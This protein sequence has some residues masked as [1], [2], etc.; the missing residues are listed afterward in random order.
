[1]IRRPP[2]ATRTDPLFPYTTLFRSTSEIPSDTR[3]S[4]CHDPISAPRYWTEPEQFPVAGSDPM[5]ELSSVDL[6]APLPPITVTMLPRVTA[7]LA[8]TTALTLPYRAERSVTCRMECLGL[9]VLMPHLR[10]RWML[11][12]GH[13]WHQAD[14]RSRNRRLCRPDRLPAR[15]DCVEC[16]PAGLRP[17]WCR[18]P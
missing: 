10:V 14:R 13:G 12:P 18:S 16:R 5:M 9:P 11:Q 4:T 8:P 1:M 7:I 15:P 17:A 3:R 6:P 2:R